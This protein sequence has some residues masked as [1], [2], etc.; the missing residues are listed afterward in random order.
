MSF[1]SRSAP[2]AVAEQEIAPVFVL[3]RHPARACRGGVL[4]AMSFARPGDSGSTK[5]N[6]VGKKEDHCEISR[7]ERVVQSAEPRQLA[8]GAPHVL[9]WI[10]FEDV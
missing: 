3:S 1:E 7:V 5:S 8:P 10:T 4:E 9:R 6:R 2:L